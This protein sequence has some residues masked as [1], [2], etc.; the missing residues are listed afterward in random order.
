MVDVCLLGQD[1]GGG[2][3]GGGGGSGDGGNGG[4]GETNKEHL[5]LNVRKSVKRRV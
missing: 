1:G 3:V 4:G 5:K 2:G